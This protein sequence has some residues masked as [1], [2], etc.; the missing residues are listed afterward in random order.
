MPAVNYTQQQLPVVNYLFKVE[1]TQLH[2]VSYYW[3]VMQACRYQWYYQTL[4]IPLVNTSLILNSLAEQIGNFSNR[5]SKHNSVYK[6][7]R[8]WLFLAC[9]ITIASAINMCMTIVHPSLTQ[10]E[11]RT[12]LDLSAFSCQQISVSFAVVSKYNISQYSPRSQICVPGCKYM[13]TSLAHLF[14]RHSLPRG[15]YICCYYIIT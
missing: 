9:D 5:L 4:A 14:Y 2:R 15:G 7:M 8:I 13:H 3:K 10:N 6:C 12:P 1:A 11:L